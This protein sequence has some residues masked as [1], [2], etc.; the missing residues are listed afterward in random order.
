MVKAKATK[1]AEPQLAASST[2]KDW[3][4]IVIIVLVVGI[5]FRDIL[6]QNAFFW[7]DF[8]FQY[9]AF[10]DFAAVS[11]A[12]GTL[13][14]WNPYTFSGMPFQADIQT[15]LF[16]IPNLLLTL[17]VNG[18]R[19]SFYW[20]EVMIVAHFV[21]AGVSM[22]FFA[23]EIGQEKPYALFSA[24]AFTLSGFMIMQVI[25]QTFVCQVAWLPLILLCLRR[26][27]L[28]KSVVSMV[29][30]A[31]ILGHAILAGAPQFTVYIFLLI[32]FYF[33]FEWM[34]SVRGM[35]WKSTLPLVPLA[36]GV[37]V[38]AVALTAIQ[39]L[40]TLELAPL[41][42]RATITFENSSEGSFRWEQMIT[43]IAPK[44]FGASGAIEHTYAFPERYWSY[45]E[46][47]IYVGILP[48]VTAAIALLQWR[49]NRYV[50]FFAIIA[51]FGFFYCL[52]DNFILHSFFFH[53]IPGF[54]KFRVPGRMSLF[55]TMAV[56]VLSG[57][58]LR[59]AVQEISQNSRHVWKF[60][61]IVFGCG[62][63]VLILAQSGFLQVMS[64]ANA[65]QDNHEK[66]VQSASTA[67]GLLI[68]ASILLFL[69]MRQRTLGVLATLVLVGFHVVDMNLFGFDQNNGRMSPDQ[70]YSRTVQLVDEL[71]AEGKQEYF[72]I[73]SR[74]GGYM[75][76]DRNQGMVDRVFLLEGYTPLGL[77]RSYPP[78]HSTDAVYGLLNAKYRIEV[79]RSNGA[80]SLRQA[81]AYVP[82]A[83]VVYD[84]TVIS[85]EAAA[86]SYM[87]SA[88]FNPLRTVMFEQDPHLSLAARTA[89]PKAPTIASITAYDL[90]EIHLAVTSDQNGVLV[91]SEIN[92]PGWN[93]YVNDVKTPVYQANW[94]LRAV[95]IPQGA[96]QVV[97]KF[98]PKSFTHGVF[99][100]LGTIVLS[101]VLIAGSLLK[102][103][104]ANVTTS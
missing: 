11:L 37:V 88:E 58:G 7:E 21:I 9:Y 3:Q 27:L 24:A 67:F 20:V 45:W 69:I 16:Y 29:L 19:L 8:I 76:L 71:K 32:L 13:P 102:R 5:F 25:H 104:R 41:S 98:E 18:E 10:R 81:E 62:L 84:D 97:L 94:S 77:Q 70:Y 66:A 74:D 23:K 14:L 75:I 30:T 65:I 61:G 55:M 101:V 82:R 52:G 50:S 78:G 46:T 49:K 103:R 48:L 26:T 43:L 12:H 1:L 17:F 42:R 59:Y 73:N 38:L 39:L 72:R 40:P 86:K 22:Y 91:L 33:L 53:I 68:G 56:S 80:M 36:A 6:L 99:I 87:E 60:V 51:L 100:T 57:F 2:L 79:N 85:D 95:P 44:Y 35:G 96:T 89:E 83:F 63:L 92:Y 64:N 4:A 31:L 34:G 93:A 90:N 28:R 15:A 54:D 47:C